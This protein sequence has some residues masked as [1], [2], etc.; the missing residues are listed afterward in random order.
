V[1]DL[2]LLGDQ[3]PQLAVI[4]GDA[5]A[6]LGQGGFELCKVV[7]DTKRGRDRET[8]LVTGLAFATFAV[9]PNSRAVLD[10]FRA[11]RRRERPSPRT[12]W[13]WPE[14]ANL[15]SSSASGSIF[16]VSDQP[17]QGPF[18]SLAPK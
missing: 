3:P 15:Y 1:I 7:I 5:F 4:G 18:V 2:A 9:G 10:Y 6:H 16:R 14:N 13:R 8:R 12:D 11:K 17:E